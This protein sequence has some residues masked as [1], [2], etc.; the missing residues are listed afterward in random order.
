M[1][2][3]NIQYEVVVDVGGI[4]RNAPQ[5][6]G[7]SPFARNC[8][9]ADTHYPC[10]RPVFDMIPYYM[11]SQSI[12]FLL[13]RQMAAHANNIGLMTHFDMISKCVIILLECAVIWCNN[14]NR[15][16]EYINSGVTSLYDTQGRLS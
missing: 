10:S 14:K 1:W 11:H 7:L 4:N 2:I 16:W 9:K 8:V 15:L 3:T 5:H 13:L 6:H 12:F